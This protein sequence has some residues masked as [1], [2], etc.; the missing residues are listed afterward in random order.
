MRSSICG[1]LGVLAALS[2]GAQPTVY[3]GGAVNAASY[4]AAGLP[5]YGIAQ[6]SIFMVFGQGLG[7]DSPAMASFPLPTELG[8][9]SIQVTAGGVAVQAIMLKCAST[10]AQAILPSSTPTG[11]GTLT[12]T[13]QGQTSAPI[14]VKVVKSGFGIFTRNQAGSGPASIDNY[15]SDTDRP[16][17]SHIQAAKPGQVVT[18]WGTGLGPVTFDETVP[19][20]AVDL[21]LPIQVLVNGRSAQILYKGRSSEF[22]GLDQINFVIP[23]NSGG[24][25]YSS[26]AVKIGDVVSNFAFMSIYAQNILC[27]DSD[28]FSSNDMSSLEMGGALQVGGILLKRMQGT[29]ESAGGT[30]QLLI[31]DGYARFSRFDLNGFLAANTF[32]DMWGRAGSCHVEW[33]RVS[34]PNQTDYLAPDPV[35]HGILEAGATLAF[36][37]PQGTHNISFDGNEYE[38]GLGGAPPGEP[39]KPPFLEPGQY[40]V[41]GSGG[42]NVGP[43]TATIQIPSAVTWSNKDQISQ[44]DRTGNLTITWSGGGDPTKE[45]VIAMGSSTDTATKLR[46]TFTCVA[47]ASWGSL[48][49]PSYV[50][51]RLPASSPWTEGLFP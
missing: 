18:L 37:G 38:D 50:L 22:A 45:R 47:P 44:I 40:V 21:D 17:N 25:C 10:W 9:V 27:A 29:L 51:G 41:S 12:L 11:D 49:V 34:G 3:T 6:G 16:A 7:P 36:A 43:F 28:S 13:Y 2:L 32:Y 5:D 26:L 4:L 8:G 33:M 30:T 42:K 24:G 14:G 23:E 19:P 31:D 48:T 35:Q 1:L 46:V 20:Q 39:E 15:N